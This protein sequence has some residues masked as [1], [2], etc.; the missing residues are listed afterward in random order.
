MPALVDLQLRER[1]ASSRAVMFPILATVDAIH[2][3]SDLSSL[4][5]PRTLFPQKDSYAYRVCK[6]LELVFNTCYF[7]GAAQYNS[8]MQ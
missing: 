2:N 3:N 7:S 5:Y 1:H 6:S 4:D 8:H